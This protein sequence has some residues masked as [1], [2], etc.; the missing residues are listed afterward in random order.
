M[1]ITVFGAAG[2]VGTLVVEDALRR[3]YTVVAFVHNHSLFSPS[4]K[5]IIVHGDVYKATDV[6]DA[7]QG[8]QAV[9]SCLGSWGTPKRNVLTTAME[10]LIPAME[11]AGISRIISLTGSGAAAPG[12]KGQEW[13]LKLLSPF[14]AGKVFRDGQDH[15]RMLADSDLQ[16]TT[17]RSPVMTGFGKPGYQ[18]KPKAG[19]PLA[20]VRRS[21]VATALLDQL[22]ATNFIRT[23]PVLYRSAH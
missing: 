10:A 8:S 3:G 19:G 14:P 1:Q 13:L 21:A 7:L 12:E 16:W 20:T 18:L 23:A 6:A 22:D 2:K 9:I 5:L 11:Q 4:G 15:M 17:L